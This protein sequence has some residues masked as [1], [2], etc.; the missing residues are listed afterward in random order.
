MAMSRRVTTAE[1]ARLGLGGAEAVPALQELGVWGEDGAL[2]GCEGV[3]KALGASTNAEHSLR[4]L[5]R[6]AKTQPEAWTALLAGEDLVTRAA[7]I[8]GASDALGDLLV[9]SPAAMTEL[10]GDL[11]PWDAAEVAL[12]AAAALESDDSSDALTAFQRRGLL[13]VAARDLLGFADTPAIAAELA[14]LA[15]GVLAAALDHVVADLDCR[16]AVIGMGKLGGRELNYVSDVDVLFVGAGDRDAMTR[17]AERF[18]RLLGRPTPQGQTYEIDANLRP[19]GRDG[20]LVRTLDSYAQYYERW[21]KTWEFQALLKARPVAGDAE[22]GAAFT[23]LITPFVWPDRLE[24]DR[25]AEIQRMKEVVERSKPVQRHGARQ[26]K[27]A[28]GGLRDIEF[29]VQLLQLVHGRHDPLLRS[30]NTLTALTALA[31]GGYVDEGDAQL[32]SD[33]YQF[34]RTVEHRIQLVRLRRSHTVPES[35]EARRRIARS[36]GFRDIRAASALV[37]FDREY[38]RVQG[39][40]RRLHEKLFY[41]PLLERFA[42]VG[43]AEQLATGDGKLDEESARERLSAL[44]FADP[45]G[46]MAH[47]HALAS[48]VSRRA[49]L[50]RTLL[51]A[52]LPTLA[53]A[54]DPDG[55]LAAFRSL[56]DKL[57]ESPSFLRTLRDNPPVGELLARVLGSSRV[58]G[59]WLER[60]PEVFS[61]LADLPGLQRHLDPGE[62]RRLATGLL[63][64]GDD[65]DRAGDSLRR[66]KRREVARV[67]IR[68]LGGYADP[69]EV[70]EELTGV[71]EM[72]LEA[73][74]ALLVSSEVRFAVIGMGKL[75]GR[76]LGYASDL[77]VLLVYES[78][79]SRD[80]ATRSAERL[81]TLLSGITPE[82]QAFHVDLGLRPEGKDGPLVRTI[83]SYRQYYE[84]WAQPWEF[85]ALTLARPVAGDPELATTFLEMAHEHVYPQ[86]PPAARLQ[87]VRQMKARVERERAGGGGVG[88]RTRRTRPSAGA[89]PRGDSDA[90]RRTS[91]RVD[92]KLGEGGLSD[93]EWTVQLLQLRHGGRLP[94]LRGP[95]TLSALAALEAEEL[96]GPRD[97]QWLRE[98]WV[99]L[100]RLRNALYLMGERDTSELPQSPL[101]QERLA[102]ML[103]YDAPGTQQL[104]E[105]LSRSLRRVR[106]VHEQSFYDA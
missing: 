99:L 23:E 98:G 32:F 13:H 27:L 61:T 37:Q 100:T 55:G 76:E 92:L 36:A 81:L 21:A 53:A 77:D 104:S 28:P 90:L 84:R 95:G 30:P 97:A 78:Q 19:E 79:S 80:L 42:E 93:V 50:F 9:A 64:R 57:G 17:G 25:V 71:A 87:A 82:G 83:D 69:V 2:P 48:G 56:A 1:L 5:V 38:L 101:K 73:A 35:E 29:A 75:G 72:C 47:L 31:D 49:R 46:A 91:K 26:L 54:P 45:R 85:Q 60:Q 4:G 105:D 102:R 68:D 16:L 7:T 34:L 63:R 51:P 10:L 43:S 74:V 66:M 70:G 12:Q 52:V 59:T 65:L 40:V 44:G 41:R 18:M 96:L 39:Y 6:F 8:W 67:A 103:G 33:A 89:R 88:G 22:L 24:A 14:D 106:K 11:H 20:A 3:V 15:E 58:V 62:Y 94:V 86:T